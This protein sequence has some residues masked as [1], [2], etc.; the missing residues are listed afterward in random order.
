MIDDEKELKRA[1]EGLS[2]VEGHGKKSLFTYVEKGEGFYSDGS[3]ISHHVY[4]YIGGYGLS[5]LLV[6][7]QLS[8]V[9]QDSPY[10][11]GDAEMEVIYQSIKA[12]FL[13]VTFHGMIMGHVRGRWCLLTLVSNC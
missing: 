1:R 6:T 2:D 9:L 7:S 12:T 5:H 8:L 10:S 11:I 4:P 13:P 3:Y